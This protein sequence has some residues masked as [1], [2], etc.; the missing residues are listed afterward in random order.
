MECFFSRDDNKCSSQFEFAK[1]VKIA[2]MKV[3]LL[4]IEIIFLQF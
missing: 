4:K 3:L 2:R 1:H